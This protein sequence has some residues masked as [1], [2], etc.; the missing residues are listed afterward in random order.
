MRGCLA[1]AALLLASLALVACGEDDESFSDG[2]ISEA[3]EVKDDAVGGDP[4]CVVKDFLNDSG[5]VG[6]VDAKDPALVSEQG[7][8][9]VVVKPPF[10]DDCEQKVRKGLDRLDPRPK[11]E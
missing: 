9:G 7:N 4:F 10:P 8:I 2:R 5:E 1:A 3:I 11:E 6:E